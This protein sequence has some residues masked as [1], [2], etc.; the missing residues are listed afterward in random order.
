MGPFD[1]PPIPFYILPFMT[2]PKADLDV[3]RT[4]IDLS[5]PKGHSVNDGV[6]KHLYINTELK[7]KYPS[8]D[9]IIQTLINLGPSCS[10]FKI[11]ISCAFRHIRIDPG[12]LDLLGLQHLKQ[13][14]LD[15][16][17]LFGYRL[18]TIYFRN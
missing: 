16:L 13:Y 17:L 11:D 4:I 8:V 1:S 18:G 9:S 2:R 12:D 14:Y 3:R 5:W 15:L 10:I 6:G 7:L